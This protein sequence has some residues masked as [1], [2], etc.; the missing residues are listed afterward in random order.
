MSKPYVFTAPGTSL[1]VSISRRP[2]LVA[3]VSAVT[4]GPGPFAYTFQGTFDDL[5][6]V[7]PSVADWN[8]F[9]PAT[10]GG[11]G[12]AFMQIPDP[13]FIGLRCVVSACPAGSTLTFEVSG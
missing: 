2:G 9:V 13:N 6:A 5:G 11:V 7:D 8:S 3:S 12:S 1:A 10:N 4:S